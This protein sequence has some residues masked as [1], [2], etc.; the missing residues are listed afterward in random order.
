VA[1]ARDAGQVGGTPFWVREYVEGT[2]LA[3][4][5]DVEPPSF[6]QRL[7]PADP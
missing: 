6:E 5:I 7:R 2:D 4:L 1:Y 3:R